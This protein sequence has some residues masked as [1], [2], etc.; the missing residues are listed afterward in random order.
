MRKR[1]L[2]ALVATISLSAPAPAQNS[3]P[4]GQTITSQLA[5]APTESRALVTWD[6]I[7]GN[8]KRFKGKV[9][10]QWGRL[11]ND[12]LAVAQGRREELVGKIQA[13]YGIDKEQ[14]DKQV[15]AW[16]QQQK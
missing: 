7:A 4:E 15:E 1:I 16:L 8:W 6:K 12:D 10:K 9:R 2:I 14:A 11:T 3:K 13:R 5:P